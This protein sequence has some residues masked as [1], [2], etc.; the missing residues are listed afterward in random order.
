MTFDEMTAPELTIASQY[1]RQVIDLLRA[2]GADV[3]DFLVRHHLSEAQLEDASFTFTYGAFRDFILDAEATAREPALGLLV[4]ERLVTRTHGFVGHAA[5][6]SRTMR[7]MLQVLEQF[8]S[9]RISV[10]SLRYEVD[11]P[12]V[13]VALH[14][15]FP[16]G[17]LQRVVSEAA[18]VSVRN[19]VEAVSMGGWRVERI[20]FAFAPPEYA[21][22]ARE[23]VGCRVDYGRT[24]TGIVLPAR[25][26]D[27]PLKTANPAAFQEA[28]EICRHQMEALAAGATIADRVCRSL[29]SKQNSFPSL[30]TTARLLHMTPRTLH[31]KLIAEG[32]SYRAILER[33]RHDLA[34]AHLRGGRMS[35]EEIAYILGY[36]DPSNF[37]RAFRR[38]TSLSPSAYREKRLPAIGLTLE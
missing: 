27:H 18:V 26:L 14:E 19:I 8:L 16:L 11:A 1:L 31:R 24:W 5:A 38:W 17:D 37:R 33:T 36:S 2:G 9:V 20:S 32:T 35:I 4:G 23:F 22:F 13:R 12:E 15:L 21:R 28:A 3:D 7:D 34:I 25:L 30:E 29:L 10:L 6:N